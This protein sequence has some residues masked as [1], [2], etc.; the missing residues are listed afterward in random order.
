MGK[1]DGVRVYIDGR[2]LIETSAASGLRSPGTRP[3][4]RQRADRVIAP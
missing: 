1:D 4:V 3:L 2:L